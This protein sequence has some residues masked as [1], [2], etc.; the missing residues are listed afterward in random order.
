MRSGR[1][2][3]RGEDQRIVDHIFVPTGSQRPERVRPQSNTVDLGVGQLPRLQVVGVGRYPTCAPMWAGR[4]LVY[5]SRASATIVCCFALPFSR[6]GLNTFARFSSYFPKFPRSI[7]E[8]V[9][10][11]LIHP[12][13]HPSVCSVRSPSHSSPVSWPSITPRL[14]P[15]ALA[16]WFCF[17]VRT[18]LLSG[19]F[20]SLAY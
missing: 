9:V 16:P 17:T 15:R 7:P 14:S 1:A 4:T 2:R 3:G 11:S 6:T 18:R 19:Y 20:R 5:P 13:P 12:L 10:A 8:K